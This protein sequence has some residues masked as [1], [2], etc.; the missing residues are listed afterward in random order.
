MFIEDAGFDDFLAY[1]YNKPK[2]WQEVTNTQS[3]PYSVTAYQ[4]N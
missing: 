1:F 4:E 2:N 3:L